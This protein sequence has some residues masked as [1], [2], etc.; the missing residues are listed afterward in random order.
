MDEDAIVEQLRGDG[1]PARSPFAVLPGQ[2]L[3]GFRE[4]QWRAAVR[5]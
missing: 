1:M 5:A 2:T 4:A 3:V